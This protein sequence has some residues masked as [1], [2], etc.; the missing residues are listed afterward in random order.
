[1]AAL[2]WL[3]NLDFSASPAD[4]PPVVDTPSSKGAGR[5][6]RRRR[7]VIRIEGRVFTA[8]SEAEALAILKQ[9]EALAEIAATRKAEEIVER[10]LPKAMSLGAVKPINIKTP[11]VEASPELE[12]QAIETMVAISR[13]YENA[14]MLA[15]MRLLLALAEEE[16]EELWLLS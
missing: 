8:E 11:G 2:G 4:T 16:E 7:Y 6:R 1:M 9:A 13:A 15:E 14:S 3:L 5:S 12:A 10:A